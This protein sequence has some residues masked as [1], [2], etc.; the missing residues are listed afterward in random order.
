[1]KEGS[2]WSDYSYMKPGSDQI[3]MEH[4]YSKLF[5]YADK[6]YIVYCGVWKQRG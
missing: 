5:R 1:M 4:T 2:G 6:N 3:S